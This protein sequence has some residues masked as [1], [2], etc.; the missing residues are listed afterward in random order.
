MV[1]NVELVDSHAERNCCQC[2]QCVSD[3][4]NCQTEHQSWSFLCDVPSV[5]PVRGRSA[6]RGRI[7]AYVIV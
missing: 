1:T 3:V 7:A 5:P 6:R 4:A 2:A